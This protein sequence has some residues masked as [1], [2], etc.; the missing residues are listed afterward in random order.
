MYKI[1][2]IYVWKGIDTEINTLSTVINQ[3][4]FQ[5]LEIGSSLV[6]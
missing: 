4:L 5:K 6:N 2:N 1:V 3:C